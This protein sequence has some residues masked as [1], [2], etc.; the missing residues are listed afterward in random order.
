MT[1]AVPYCVAGDST[2]LRT[3]SPLQAAGLAHA[4]PTV[5]PSAAVQAK[6]TIQAQVQVPTRHTSTM[7]TRHRSE[8][9]VEEYRPVDTRQS[10]AAYLGQWRK[11]CRSIFDVIEE[12]SNSSAVDDLRGS[13]L[14]RW[15][16][17]ESAHQVH[18]A[19]GEL[20][21]RK[22]SKL[23]SQHEQYVQDNKDAIRTLEAYLR[24]ELKASLLEPS[25]PR[26]EP[27]VSQ[28]TQPAPQQVQERRTPKPVPLVREDEIDRLRHSVRQMEL[29]LQET[30]SRLGPR[31]QSTPFDI[32]DKAAP[33]TP[34]TKGDELTASAVD[35]HVRSSPGSH[36]EE[37]CRFVAVDDA[38]PDAASSTT[39]R[40]LCNKT[41]DTSYADPAT[42]PASTPW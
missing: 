37:S 18:M 23:T 40:R 7:A 38:C 39:T 35:T 31:D 17:Y 10:R 42:A 5:T 16:L 34:A 13:I 25:T 27:Q 6:S 26:R 41:K 29:K 8:T 24:R 15:R 11:L 12:P 4:N 9:E 32:R 30:R 19:E 28:P 21:E 20:T 14:R 3:K 36:A 33:V 2:S 22:A 1:S